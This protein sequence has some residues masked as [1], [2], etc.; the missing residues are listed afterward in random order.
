MCRSIC[1][2]FLNTRTALFKVLNGHQRGSVLTF[3]SNF[4]K[5]YFVCL[6]AI[7]KVEPKL[8]VFTGKLGASVH[9]VYDYRCVVSGDETRWLLISLGRG[10]V[11]KWD[12]QPSTRWNKVTTRKYRNCC[13]NADKVPHLE[14]SLC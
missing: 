6:V 10:A 11:W 7:F 14:F 5:V 12:G 1:S 8:F 4:Q 9:S 3:S 2:I 13:Y